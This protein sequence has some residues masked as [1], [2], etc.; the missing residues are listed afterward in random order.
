MWAVMDVGTNSCRL[1]IADYNKSIN[2]IRS[3]YRGLKTTR[4][5]QGVNEFNKLINQEAMTRTLEAL[6]EFKKTISSYQIE[7]LALVATQAVREAENGYSFS[8]LV[9]K[10]LGWEM[11]ILSGQRE[12]FL[13]YKGA[14]SEMSICDNPL[15]I[16]IGGGSTEF[17]GPTAG[18]NLKSLS[19]PI[20][21]LKLLEKPCED[22]GILDLFKKALTDSETF[23]LQGNTLVGVGGTCTTLAAVKLALKEYQ[24]EKV[25]GIRISRNETEE[26][27]D[28]LS[29][30]S[31]QERLLIDGIAPGREDL[32]IP[33]LQILLSVLDFLDR[34]EI[35]IS[36]HD[37]LHGLVLEL[38]GKA[39]EDLED[40]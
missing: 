7:G 23:F 14:V 10:E 3:F 32:I 22:Q 27:H 17:T 33:G 35:I 30:L 11:E 28:M 2:T 25:Q 40:V 8:R 1:M 4:M 26:I 24:P 36:D 39:Q 21:A 12:A 38:A 16:D 31:L 5:G 13:S 6:L 37:L 18:G 20:G 34:K 19:V 29:Y 9:Q 15:V